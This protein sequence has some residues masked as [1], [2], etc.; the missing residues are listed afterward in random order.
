MLKTLLFLMVLIFFQSVSAL[1]YASKSAWLI[2]EKNKQNTEFDVFYVHPTLLRDAA[3]PYPDF[4]NAK[5]RARLKGFSAAQT[6]IFG[7]AARVFVPA[8]RQLE[9]GRCLAGDLKTNPLL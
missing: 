3:K 8:V 2:A 6:G 4:S 1:N 5:V 9:I 7:N